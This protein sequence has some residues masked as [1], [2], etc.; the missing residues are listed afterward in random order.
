MHLHLL[1]LVR[2]KD[3]LCVEQEPLIGVR[4]CMCKST[5]CKQHHTQHSNQAAAA[6]LPC[7]L[8]G[9]CGTVIMKCHMQYYIIENKSGAELFSGPQEQF[10]PGGATSCHNWRP[11]CSIYYKWHPVHRWPR[12]CSYPLHAS[13][14]SDPCISVHRFPFVT[15]PVPGPCSACLHAL[16]QCC[17]L[18]LSG[19]LPDGSLQ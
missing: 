11:V 16:Q 2:S 15:E 13:L 6:A 17:N 9:L 1:N 18:R 4:A 3:L 8:L 5:F 7:G 14:Y 10:R 19:H 12:A